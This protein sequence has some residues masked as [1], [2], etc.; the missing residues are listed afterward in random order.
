MC[1]QKVTVYLSKPLKFPMETINIVFT[2]KPTNKIRISYGTTATIMD[3]ENCHFNTAAGVNLI[4]SPMLQEE[5]T[6][7]IKRNDFPE[8]CSATKAFP[9]LNGLILLHLHLEDLCDRIW[10][11]VTAHLTVDILLY[12]SFIDR[13]FYGMFPSGREM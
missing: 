11:D 2:A 4:G 9:L 8:F 1:P 13:F 12:T 5:W 10:L 6:H 7:P 3:S